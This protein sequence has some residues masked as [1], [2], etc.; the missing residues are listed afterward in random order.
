LSGMVFDFASCVEKGTVG[1]HFSFD[2]LS[3][4]V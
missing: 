3:H 1:V 4:H 2:W